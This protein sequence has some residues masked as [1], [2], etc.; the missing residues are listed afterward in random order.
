MRCV[1][2]TGVGCEAAV[3]AVVCVRSKEFHDAQ[4]SQQPE[5]ES[6]QSESEPCDDA[7][8]AHRPARTVVCSMLDPRGLLMGHDI[9]TLTE[10]FLHL[11]KN[12]R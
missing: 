9:L 7:L 6:E 8:P 11:I 12:Q 3:G 1:C 2:G 5:E 4:K 10:F